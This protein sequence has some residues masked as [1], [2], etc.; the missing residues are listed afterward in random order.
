MV[1]PTASFSAKL[2]KVTL[3]PYK[4]DKIWITVCFGVYTQTDS[5]FVSTHGLYVESRFSQGKVGDSR[6][7]T[8]SNQDRPGEDTRGPEVKL[9]Q[10]PESGGT[11]SGLYRHSLVRFSTPVDRVWSMSLRKIIRTL[12]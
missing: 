8:V 6:S 7:P 1:V 3:A 10:G 5:G 2:K 9:K 12:S 11:L 4:M